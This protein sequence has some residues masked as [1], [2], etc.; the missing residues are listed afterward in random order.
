LQ[1]VQVR[2]STS[3]LIPPREGRAGAKCVAVFPKTA[4]LIKELMRDDNPISSRFGFADQRLTRALGCSA[5]A[6]DCN[7]R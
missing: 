4:C 1:L 3:S 7:R 6:G 2:I 5:W